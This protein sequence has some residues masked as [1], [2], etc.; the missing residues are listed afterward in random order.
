MN[1]IVIKPR[2]WIGLALALAALVGGTFPA[3]A[4]DHRDGPRTVVAPELLGPLDI[5]DVYVFV[6]PANRNNTV[7]ALTVGG[8]GV[9][10]LSPPT[11]FPGA[12][13]EIRISNDGDPTNEELV[14]QFVFSQANAAGQQ[15]YNLVHLNPRTNQSGTI[16]SGVTGTRVARVRGGGQVVAGV[17]DDPFFFDLLAF[18]RFRSAVQA[19][20]PLAERVAPFLPPSI[21]NNFFGN[22][23]VLAVVVEVPRLNL[24]STRNNP[25][26][27][28]WAR[29]LLPDGNQFDRMGLPA[30]NTV[31]GFAQPLAGLPDIQDTFN[32]GSPATD[33]SLRDLVVP[34]LMMAF[35][36]TEAQARQVANTVLPDVIPFNTTSRSGFLNG[37]RLEDDVI[38]AELSLLTNGALPTD[39]VVNDSPFRSTFPYLATPVPRSRTNAAVRAIRALESSGN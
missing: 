22:F 8:A 28:V 2:R 11:F 10:V 37:R 18:Q 27:T 7:L 21:P 32:S 24:Q 23:N 34:R 26:I 13:Y 35:G 14:Y 16:A 30:I 36:E 39:R 4:A 31:A 29:T 25:N 9:G 20:R 19:G 33:A 17:F 3:R 5:N 1:R 12:V 15:A 38:D 6:S